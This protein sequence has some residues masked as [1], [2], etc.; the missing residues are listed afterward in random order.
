M[1][2]PGSPALGAR[3]APILVYDGECAFCSRWVQF[4]LR[5][6]RRRRTLRFAPR[7]GVAGRAVRA[8][9][10]ALVTVESMVWVDADEAGRERTRIR[11]DATLAVLDYL[12]G[13]WRWLAR[14]ARLAPRPLRDAGYA[15][16]ARFRRRL[17]GSAPA[18]VVFSEEERARAL[19]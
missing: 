13:G 5:R 17:A 4:V 1:S 15:V 19:P 2:T 6:D 14:I 12:G 8:R 9:H 3:D 7:D 10:P 11:S 16:V 18:C